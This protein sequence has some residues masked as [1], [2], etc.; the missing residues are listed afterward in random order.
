[1]KLSFFLFFVSWNIDVMAGAQ[2]AFW[3]FKQLKHVQRRAAQDGKN[4]YLGA[5]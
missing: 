1:M 4:L 3:E 5:L 2:A